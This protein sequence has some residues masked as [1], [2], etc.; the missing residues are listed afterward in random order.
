M[1]IISVSTAQNTIHLEFYFSLLILGKFTSEAGNITW[2][3]DI[4]TYIIYNIGNF[5]LFGVN[6]KYCIREDIFRSKSDEDQ[7]KYFLNFLK[8][9]TAKPQ[10]VVSKD[11]KTKVPMK[12]K[13]VAKKPAQRKRPINAKTVNKK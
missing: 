6:R 5:R 7:K 8:S 2:D 12:A 10:Y 4:F 9:S 3:G 13:D 1:L 11:G